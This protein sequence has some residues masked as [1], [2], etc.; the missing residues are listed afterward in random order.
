MWFDD[1]SPSVSHPCATAEKAC[2]CFTHRLSA[3]LLCHWLW[4]FGRRTSSTKP[5]WP[6]ILD[7][8]LLP[9]LLPVLPAE[10]LEAHLLGPLMAQPCAAAVASSRKALREGILQHRALGFRLRGF[11]LRLWGAGSRIQISCAAQNRVAAFEA[12]VL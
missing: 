3:R 5:S 4:H 1:L 11:G 12:K 6:H 9:T 8:K 2:T 10:T 7:Q